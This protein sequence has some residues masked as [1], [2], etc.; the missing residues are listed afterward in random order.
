M[1]AALNP[2]SRIEVAAND[3]HGRPGSE[4]L[5]WIQNPR[6]LSSDGTGTD[7]DSPVALRPRAIFTT[8]TMLLKGCVSDSPDEAIYQFYYQMSI[9]R[10]TLSGRFPC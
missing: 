1:A 9:H 8:F 6:V 4:D 5:E 2:P 7:L 10:L 3:R